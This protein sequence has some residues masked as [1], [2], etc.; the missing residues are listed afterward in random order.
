[1]QRLLQRL[2]KFVGFSTDPVLRNGLYAVVH[3]IKIRRLRRPFRRFDEVQLMCVASLLRCF[4]PMGWRQG[5]SILD[6]AQ[7]SR[8]HTSLSTSCFT[9]A[10]AQIPSQTMTDYGFWWHWMMD[11]GPKASA[12]Q[13]LSFWQLCAYSIVNSFSSVEDLRG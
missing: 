6:P 13:S 5:T 12:D 10:R 3:Q 7:M 9:K 1:M 2:Q 8:W 4:S 11:D